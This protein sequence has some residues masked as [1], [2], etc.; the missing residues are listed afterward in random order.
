MLGDHGMHSKMIFLEG[1]VHV[2]LMMRVPRAIKAGTVVSDRVS[3]R[4]VASAVLNYL[5][6]P[7][8]PSHGFRLRPRV[9]GRTRP[10]D[11]VA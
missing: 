4:D 1:S 9:E 5:G 2:P 3:S 10:R 6:M 8:P 7:M 11:M